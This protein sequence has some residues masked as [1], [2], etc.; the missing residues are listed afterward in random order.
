MGLRR[1]IADNTHEK[2]KERPS[3]P[4]MRPWEYKA[5]PEHKAHSAHS[6][7]SKLDCPNDFHEENGLFLAYKKQATDGPT[8]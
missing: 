5:H 8:D 2:V 7:M 1:S 6:A 4:M 3:R